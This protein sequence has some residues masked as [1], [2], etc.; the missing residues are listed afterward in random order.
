MQLGSKIDGFLYRVY[1]RLWGLMRLWDVHINCGHSLGATPR[2]TVPSEGEHPSWA[3]G[4]LCDRKG[5]WAPAGRKSNAG[6]AID[7]RQWRCGGLGTVRSDAYVVWAM[8][9]YVL[10][11]IPD[12]YGFEWHVCRFRICMY[13]FRI[14]EKTILVKYSSICPSN[15][16]PRTCLSNEIMSYV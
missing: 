12:C 6:N 13:R 3:T 1:V 10:K 5:R 14:Q 7:G 4:K 16:F 11:S 15:N 8:W 2:T 9:R